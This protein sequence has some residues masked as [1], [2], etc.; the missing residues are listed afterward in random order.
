[1]ISIFKY[2]TSVFDVRLSA[3]IYLLAFNF[4]KQSSVMIFSSVAGALYSATGYQN[5][6]YILSA[7]VLIITVV[8]IYTLQN[9]KKNAIE[10]RNA[11]LAR[12]TM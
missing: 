5:T 9:D 2:I 7:I 1:L 12:K 3:T 4:A 6:Y 11:Q 10:F 8:S